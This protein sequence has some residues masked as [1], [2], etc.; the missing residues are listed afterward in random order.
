[1]IVRPANINCDDCSNLPGLLA[2]P[3]YYPLGFHMFPWTVTD[4]EEYLDKNNCND[5]G[6]PKA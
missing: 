1:M 3:L 4:D 6:A 2:E 5:D